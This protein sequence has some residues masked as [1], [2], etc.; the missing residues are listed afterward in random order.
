M[1]ERCLG[2]PPGIPQAGEETW[3]RAVRRSLDGHLQQAHQG[4]RE[5]HEAREHVCGGLL[6]GGQPHENSAA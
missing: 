5:D 3:S 4:G 1:G 2:D 6:G